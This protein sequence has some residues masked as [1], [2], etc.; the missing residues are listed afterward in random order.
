MFDFTNENVFL[1]SDT[2]F[3]HNKL[4]KSYPDHFDQVRKYDTT[5]QMD[6]D[7]ITM[8]NKTITDNDIVIFMGDFMLCVP[9][10]D[11][12]KTVFHSYFDKLN[13][14]KQFYW[15]KGNHDEKLHQRI[16]E[17]E[18]LDNMQFVKGDKIYYVQ[19]HDFGE[20]HDTMPTDINSNVV[21]VH[22]HTHQ[23]TSLSRFDYNDQSYIQNCVCWDA[24]YR[25]VNANELE[26]CG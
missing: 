11:R 25:P 22:G 16:P 8:W 19:H 21:F 17:I 3:N 5:Q 20:V 24:W 15:I 18:M 23:E 12:Y 14:G 13:K 1:V 9:G 6:E 4:V 10:D 26:V 2:H 7:V